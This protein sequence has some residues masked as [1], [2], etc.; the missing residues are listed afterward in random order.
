MLLNKRF[1]LLSL[2]VILL[3]CVSCAREQG[4]RLKI[5]VSP[6]G[7]THDF[8][9]TVKAGAD[10]AAKELGVDI[11]WKGP[12][13]ET[14]IAGQ[15]AILEDY[16]NKRVDA[17]VMA[18]CDTK[19]LIPVVEEAHRRGIP[20][21]TIDSGLD[22][23]IPLSFVASD[24]VRGAEKAADILAQLVDKKGEVAC[25]NFIP[26]AATAIWRETGFKE[27][28]KKY[29]EITL[30]ALQYCQADVATA[31]AVTENILTAQPGLKGIFAT[32]EAGAIGAA[33]ALIARNVQGKVKLVA[34][35]AS[36]NEIEALQQGVIQAVIV[37]N[38]FGM[39]YIGVKSAVDA[40]N[41]KSLEKVIDTGTTVITMDNFS[42]PQ[43]QK[44]LYPLGKK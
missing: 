44:I 8:W 11:V 35:D 37:Q 7:L 32:N 22:S 10:S 13:L 9:L 41:G 20:V 21:I 17:I 27:G 14:D 26:G 31:M 36:P 43:I 4:N 6:K 28:L 12:P 19:A 23:D 38:P 5:L 29:P 40:I 30:A 15:I 2:I 39:G 33:Q 16:I 3:T 42:D 24:N 34:F 25:V 18:A 1:L